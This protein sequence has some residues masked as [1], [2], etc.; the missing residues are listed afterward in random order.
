[1]EQS[2]HTVATNTDAETD[3]QGRERLVGKAG[4]GRSVMKITLD[5]L[6]DNHITAEHPL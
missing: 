5:I 1:M 6:E 2:Y 3:A 4:K